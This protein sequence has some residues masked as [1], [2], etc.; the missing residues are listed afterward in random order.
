MLQHILKL[1][2]SLLT[3]VPRAEF[4][5]EM[6]RLCCLLRIG[7]VR[8]LRSGDASSGLLPSFSR[9]LTQVSLPSV[10]AGVPSTR[11]DPFAPLCCPSGVPFEGGLLLWRLRIPFDASYSLWNAS[12]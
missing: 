2:L 4:V 5:G 3:S 12:T 8:A 6:S 10:C 11:A 7:E 9:I 1:F